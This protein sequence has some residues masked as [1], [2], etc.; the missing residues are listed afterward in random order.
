MVGM[1]IAF[2]GLIGGLA[3]KAS[4]DH[5]AIIANSAK[6]LVA[7]SSNPIVL[8]FPKTLGHPLVTADYTGLWV[9]LIVALLGVML[10]SAGILLASVKPRVS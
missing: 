7:S 1:L 5:V 9:G 6:W 3:A 8:T 2:G 4:A 10:L